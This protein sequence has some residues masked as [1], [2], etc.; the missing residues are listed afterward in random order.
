LRVLGLGP[1][2]SWRQVKRAYRRLALQ[3]HPDRHRGEAV[4]TPF[5]SPQLDHNARFRQVTTAFT[6]LERCFA[7]VETDRIP[8]ACARC[9]DYE[10]LEMGLDGNAYCETCLL[11]ADGKRALPAPPVTVAGCGLAILG[12]LVSAVSLGLWTTNGRWLYWGI[13]VA[14]TFGALIALAA[15]CF[16]VQYAVQR[17]PRRSHSG[18]RRWQIRPRR[19][20]PSPVVVRKQGC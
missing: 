13:S 4:A 8:E 16:T 5:G 11:H 9:G 3:Y 6:V 17:Q 12:L 18:S 14:A 19:V 20:K 7:A 1:C 10:T 15:V 2:A